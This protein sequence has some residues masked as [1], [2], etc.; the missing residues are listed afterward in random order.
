MDW[1][2]DKEA[3]VVAPEDPECTAPTWLITLT[4]LLPLDHSKK[5]HGGFLFGSDFLWCVCE[6]GCGCVWSEVLCKLFLPWETQSI[7]FPSV[8]IYD[9]AAVLL[10]F[11]DFGCVNQ[12]VLLI[13]Q[14][15]LLQNT[16]EA[17]SAT[18]P[19]IH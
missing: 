5:G 7:V 9:F 19:H 15:E 18:M 3:F 8:F 4:L 11:G 14:G 6:C 2:P 16:A 13:P 17:R 1:P 12:S 10:N